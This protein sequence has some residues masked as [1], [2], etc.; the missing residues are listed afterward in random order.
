MLDEGKG[1]YHVWLCFW[2]PPP[3]GSTI[4]GFSCFWVLWPPWSPSFLLSWPHKALPWPR[5][6]CFP[7][8][9]WEKEGC[10]FCRQLVEVKAR[11]SSH[12]GC[13]GPRI[14]HFGPRSS[15]LPLR[16]TL[17]PP[18]TLPAS[19]EE[20]DYSQRPA[21]PRNSQPICGLN[22]SSFIFAESCC[23]FSEYKASATTRETPAPSASV[24]AFVGGAN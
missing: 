21:G 1:F 14:P 20:D 10:C 15:L 23:I 24:P 17:P 2:L 7:V 5:P 9:C 19:Q 13:L 4:H 22:A 12:P 16:S 11:T 18:Q 3:D 6:P 8:V